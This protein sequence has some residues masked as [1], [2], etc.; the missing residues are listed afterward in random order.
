[1]IFLNHKRTNFK[2]SSH[3]TFPSFFLEGSLFL[4]ATKFGNC[5]WKLFFLRTSHSYYADWKNL[6][7]S[8]Q[9]GLLKQTVKSL[10]FRLLNFSTLATLHVL[11][12]FFLKLFEVLV[13]SRENTC[14]SFLFEPKRFMVYWKGKLLLSSLFLRFYAVNFHI[15][16]SRLY[17]FY[18]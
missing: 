8:L 1:M 4:L 15:K 2:L 13:F 12:P 7:K 18:R 9:T 14:T 5:R 16:C 11:T 6:N 3:N 17:L 10:N